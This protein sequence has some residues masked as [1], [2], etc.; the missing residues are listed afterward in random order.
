MSEDGYSYDHI[1]LVGRW[2]SNAFLK[3]IKPSIITIS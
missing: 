2:N 3:Y 1:K